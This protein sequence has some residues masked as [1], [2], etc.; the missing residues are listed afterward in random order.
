MPPRTSTASEAGRQLPDG[1]RGPTRT[2]ARSLAA[3]AADCT[4]AV[5]CSSAAAFVAMPARSFLALGAAAVAAVALSTAAR[6]QTRVAPTQL[7][8]LQTVAVNPLAIPFG[9]LSGEY[10]VSLPTPGLTVGVGG[11][12]TAGSS[13]YSDED[14]WIE[15]RAMYYPNEV[16]LSGFG[17]GVTLGAHRAKSDSRDVTELGRRPHDSGATLGV[18]GSYNFLLGRQQRLVFGIGAGAKRVLKKVSNDSPLSQVYPDG[19][20]V[21]GFAF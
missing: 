20:L 10:E 3:R 16:A 1:R 5:A 6:A 12:I 17:I 4:R 21:I 11:T 2:A 19:R 7:P 14:R 18:L 9:I 15:G 13:I 8:Y